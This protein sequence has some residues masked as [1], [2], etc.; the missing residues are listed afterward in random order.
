MR[1]VVAGSSGLVGSAL[2]TALRAD[3]HDVLRLVRRAPKG[4]D[5]LR[6]DPAQPLDPAGLGRVDVS[7]RIG[8]DGAVS[9][10]LHFSSP[11]AADALKAHAE[12]LRSALQQ[13]GFTLGGSDLSFTT[14]GGCNGQAGQG[15][16]GR[17]F[18]SNAN[19]RIP[20]L[21][22]AQVHAAPPPGWPASASGLDIRI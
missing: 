10:A 3:G 4:P 2:V 8:A 21:A 17:S 12:E 18:A 6:W 1:I 14:G 19:T 16:P 7:I 11:Q 15:A 5:E 9:A 20:D 13:A 22:D